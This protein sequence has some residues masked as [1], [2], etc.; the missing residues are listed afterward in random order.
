[1]II[2]GTIHPTESSGDADAIEMIQAG[3][4]TSGQSITNY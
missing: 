2:R 4:G 3:T 1:M